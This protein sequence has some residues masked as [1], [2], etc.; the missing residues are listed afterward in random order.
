MKNFIYNSSLYSGRSAM[1]IHK[2]TGC[3]EEW[4]ESTCRFARNSSFCQVHAF[5]VLTPTST[6]HQFIICMFICRNFIP[7][8][9]L[10]SNIISCNYI[11]S[12]NGIFKLWEFYHSCPSARN[13]QSVHIVSLPA[14][15]T[16]S[17]RSAGH[18]TKYQYWYVYTIRTSNGIML[19]IVYEF[20]ALGMLLSICWERKVPSLNEYPNRW[21]SE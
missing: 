18:I 3:L 12:A 8:T 11:C 17:H 6:Y 10:S 9:I 19:A 4:R 21:L 14:W 1:A 15:R 7:S 13:K 16:R 5:D 2:I 20:I